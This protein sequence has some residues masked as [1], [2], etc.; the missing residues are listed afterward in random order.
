[1]YAIEPA[2]A[3]SNRARVVVQ[4]GLPPLR[5]VCAV[6]VVANLKDGGGR[7]R[8]GPKGHAAALGRR[9]RDT[10]FMSTHLNSCTCAGLRNSVE[11]LFV[12]DRLEPYTIFG[13][14]TTDIPPFSRVLRPRHYRAPQVLDARGYAGCY[15][16]G[17]EA[18][19]RFS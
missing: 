14:S 18:G 11:H 6:A 3:D 7:V 4:N 17:S 9:D 10:D 5:L 19:Q 8:R 2:K 12:V 16:Q 15:V 1:M 13:S